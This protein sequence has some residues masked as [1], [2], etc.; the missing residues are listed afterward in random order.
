MDEPELQGG[1]RCRRLVSGARSL[2]RSFAATALMLLTPMWVAA[3][4]YQLSLDS[5][6]GKRLSNMPENSW[7]KLSANQF[8]DA[9]TPLDQRPKPANV[10]SVGGPWAVINAWSSMAWDSNRGSLIFWGGGHANYPGNEVYRWNGNT[11]LWERASLPSDVV[12]NTQSVFTTLYEA[13]DGP[14][15]APISAHTY[16][17]SEFLPLSDRFVT[18]GGAAFNTGHFFELGTGE[19]TGPYF[20]DPSRA[21]PNAVGGTLGSQVK[22]DIYTTVTA[23]NMWQ[24]RNNLQPAYPGELKPGNGGTEWIDGTSAYAEEGGKDVLYIAVSSQLFRYTVNDLSD[25]T[26][27]TY[28]LLGRY[29]V[30]PFTGQGAGAFDPYRQLYL[31]TAGVQFTYWT[32]DNPGL[33]NQNVIFTP[34][35]TS[36]A[37]PFSN[38]RMLGMDFDPIRKSFV[39]WG[40]NR[41]VWQLTAPASLASGSWTVAPLA[42]ASTAAP[43]ITSTGAVNVGILG[44]WK[45]ARALD[46]F[47]GA[48]PGN[49]GEI[50]AYKPANWSPTV[51]DTLPFVVSPATGS[52]F[53]VGASVPITVDSVDKSVS[54]VAVYANGNAVGMGSSVPRT[55]TWTPT[56]AGS[57]TITVR[58]IG[59]D[60]VER[61]STPVS[62]TVGAPANVAP[63]VAL[64]SPAA[65]QSFTQGSAITLAASASDVD[66]TVARVEFYADGVK[67]G[68]ATSAPYSYSWSGATVGSHV[69]TA[70]AYDNAGASKTSAAI[71]ITVN[72]GAPNVP[73]TVALTSPAPG[74]SFTQGSVITLAASASDADGTVARVE[75]YA[76]GVLLGQATSAPY[77]YSWSAAA[78][79][80]HV[81]SAVAY[82]N[83]GASTT[84]ATVSVSVTAG[85]GGQT[86]TLQNGLNGYAGTSDAYIYQYFPS[87]NFGTAQM[88]EDMAGGSYR[89]RSLVRFA[90]F[91]SDGGPVPDGATITQATL[92]LYKY[93]YYDTKYQLRPV[94]TN[95]V[96][97]EVTWSQARSG[98]SWAGGGAT[99]LGTDVATSGDA[100]ADALWTP[101]WLAFDVT[102]GV[103]AMAG[104]RANRG[105]V[106]DPLSGNGNLKYFYSSEYTG[107]TTLRPVLSVQYTIGNGTNT[108]PTVSLS[109][110]TAGQSFVQGSAIALTAAANDS[111]GTVNRVEFYADG[112]KLGQA[113]SAPYSFNWSGA[114]VGP[115]V[116][117]A[118]AYD[119]SGASTTSAAVSV[120]VSAPANVA[121]TVA[122]TSPAA[123]QSFTQGSAITL[124]AS[125]SD[126]D[127]TVARVE[128]YADGVKLGQATSAPY[129]YSWSGA[130][131]GSHV[132]TAVAYDNAGA[133]KTSAA[134]SI[135]VNAGA[136]NV[137]PTVALTSPAP[138]QSFTQGSVIT[139]A[140]SASDADGTVAR[141]E[142]YADGVLLGQA[143]SA[144]YSYSWSAA[145]VGSHVLSAVAYDN[146]GASTTAA[147]VSVSVTAGAGG[148][149]VTLQNGLNGYAGTSDAY[150]YQYFPSANFGTAQM[151]EDMAGGSYRF[152]SLVRFAIFLSDGGPVPDGATITQATLSLYKYSYYDTKYQ[153]RPVLTNWVQNEVT[154][155]QARSGVSWAGGGAT[156]L[157]TDVATSGD[158]IADALWTP[159]W[160]AFDV[161]T[162][163]QAMAG[164][165]ANRGWVLD[166]LS[167]NG[168][169][170]YFYSSEYTGDTTLRPVLTI[171]YQ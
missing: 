108:P 22:P 120:T 33:S 139:L 74:Q 152:R 46:V 140:A 101:G 145:A 15:A 164:G 8:Q 89:F 34:T 167:G 53:D 102:T 87:A 12:R 95:W 148:Q 132:L 2:F 157:G 113:T 57:Y 7:V 76:D 17:N 83:T 52:T 136:P 104:G 36:G 161:T 29:I 97:N 135:T 122:L 31:R 110:P 153:L 68:Q 134:I 25:P 93:S 170:K 112:V 84:A 118:V 131:V 119:N 59:G 67:L 171:H 72:A 126:V 90:I 50:W 42:P 55:V 13:V 86:V 127:G 111:D 64:T 62:V 163:V 28:Q 133:S 116:L 94:L 35:D 159:G 123:G 121:P 162:G 141:V 151:L 44:K 129:S 156:G 6:L 115:H 27:D 144:P 49:A 11:L 81:L 48:L 23:G 100:I 51:V 21:S 32:L 155:S 56:T 37:F 43:D 91:L 30:Y 65:G 39:L 117:T 128:F 77:S 85:A 143:T 146:T 19:R 24:N 45:Y 4:S 154:W 107:D 38:L 137:P 88:L 125:A 149:T 138:G 16:D 71:S 166:P 63:T 105:W 106:L 96:Q 78:V 130:T 40:G 109:S 61:V 66:G 73:P 82:D 168:N 3:G 92:S 20:W 114:T 58:T 60:G 10:P 80:S 14:F 75:F 150:I 41:D 70:V 103:Q 165:R 47:L 124:A 54:Y 69:L 142:F 9:W 98:V 5:E 26:K 160:L 18:F 79:G 99:G 158:A 169:L 1:Q 147:T